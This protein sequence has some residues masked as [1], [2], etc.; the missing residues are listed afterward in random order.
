MQ[1]SLSFP[2]LRLF[3]TRGFF[4]HLSCAFPLGLKAHALVASCS[5]GRPKGE[6]SQGCSQRELRILSTCN[7]DS[8]LG[9]RLQFASTLGLWSAYPGRVVRGSEEPE[10]DCV[11]CMAQGGCSG[12]LS[13]TVALGVRSLCSKVS[14]CLHMECLEVSLRFSS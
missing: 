4:T 2:A 12:C 1:P 6:Q 8:Q 9:N 7:I 14:E 11:T 13:P 5:D 3:S 10:W